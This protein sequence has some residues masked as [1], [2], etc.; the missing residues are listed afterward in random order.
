MNKSTLNA[1]P[2]P[3]RRKMAKALREQAGNRRWSKK[4]RASFL[5]MAEA[6]ERTLPK[7]SGPRR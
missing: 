6:W 1:E 3:V 7:E 5:L 4:E 2:E